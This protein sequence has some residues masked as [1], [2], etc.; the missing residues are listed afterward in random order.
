MQSYN[1]ICTS[2]NIVDN[3]RVLLK[4][5]NVGG[6]HSSLY[7]LKTAFNNFYLFDTLSSKI[8]LQQIVYFFKC[9]TVIPENLS[10]CAHILACISILW[11]YNTQSMYTAQIPY[12]LCSN[13]NVWATFLN[14]F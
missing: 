11:K 3:T 5:S 2:L 9:Y 4:L 1:V 7:F 8:P 13:V 12:S 14:T 6:T 10:L